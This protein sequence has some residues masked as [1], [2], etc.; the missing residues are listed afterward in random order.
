MKDRDLGPCT[1]TDCENRAEKHSPLHGPIC[2]T[3]R[4][5]LTPARMGRTPL[6]APV[7]KKRSPLERLYDAALAYADAEDDLDYRRAASNLADAAKR[8][9]KNINH[10][11]MH[12]FPI[13]AATPP[14]VLKFP[15]RP[16]EPVAEPLERASR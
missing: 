4:K 12:T 3:H 15:T 8:Y 13:A 10:A 14:N 9:V 16:K 1:I 11:A 2:S 7:K 6:D 5:R